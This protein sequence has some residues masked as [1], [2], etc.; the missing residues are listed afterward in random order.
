MTATARNSCSRACEPERMRDS[1]Y[2]PGRT[3]ETNSTS[4]AS[5]PS[6]SPH[7]ACIFI[8][9]PDF[10]SRHCCVAAKPVATG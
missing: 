4:T 9:P 5:E 10:S 2:L 3:S 1:T 6:A 8:A 7:K